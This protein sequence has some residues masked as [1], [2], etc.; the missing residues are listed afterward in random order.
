[1]DAGMVTDPV[2][3][4]MVLG[5][6]I[7]TPMIHRGQLHGRPGADAGRGVADIPLGS[8]RELCWCPHS[9]CAGGAREGGTELPKKMCVVDEDGPDPRHP[10]AD[11]A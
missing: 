11:K 3:P 4:L 8:L 2:L 10:D 6:A 9:S 1:M 5:V 7:E